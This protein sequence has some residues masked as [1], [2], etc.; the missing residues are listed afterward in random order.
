[1]IASKKKFVPSHCFLVVF[2]YYFSRYPN[3]QKSKEIFLKVGRKYYLEAIMVGKLLPNHIEIGVNLPD[4]SNIIPITAE[5]L[6]VD[7]N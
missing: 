7:G 1:M 6:S 4:G 3:L 2:F 5:Y